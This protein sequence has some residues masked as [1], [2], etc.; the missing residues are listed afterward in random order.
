MSAKAAAGR[1]SGRGGAGGGLE[2]R[3]CG[4][5]SER[6]QKGRGRPAVGARGLPLDTTMISPR[7]PPLGR[8]LHGNR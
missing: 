7:S 5:Y 6:P 1:A 8:L 4:R 2:Q 3:A